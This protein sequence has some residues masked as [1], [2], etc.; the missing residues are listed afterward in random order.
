MSNQCQAT[1][2]QGAR[3]GQACENR[4]DATY[5]LK[6]IRLTLS[7]EA[8][9]KGIRYCDVARGC[10]AILAEGQVSCKTCL[11]KARIRDRKRDD[12]KRSDPNQCL[13]CGTQM[14]AQNRATGK[15]D[16]LLRRCVS[17]YE[18][19]LAIEENRPKRERNYKQ[20]AFQ[21]KHVA[22]NHYVK[23]A[24][25]RNIDFTLSK[26]LFES[27]LLQPCFYCGYAM[28]NQING[29][30]RVDNNKGYVEKNVV[31]CCEPCNALKGT[32]HPQEFMDKMNAIHR[33]TTD[34]T[35]IPT[36]MI[37]TWSSTYR[38]RGMTTYTAYSKGAQSRS[39]PFALSEEQFKTIVVQSCYLCGIASSLQNSNGIDRFDN[40]LGY[41]LENYRPCCGHC[42]LLKKDMS[43]DLLIKKA[44]DIHKKYEEVTTALQSYD[45]PIRAS[46]IEKRLVNDNP[47][48]AESI[49]RTYKPV[50]EIIIPSS[51]VPSI[52]VLLEPHKKRDTAPP[53]QWKVKQ[54]YEAIS[55]NQENQ[56]KDHCEQN[57]DLSKHADWPMTWATFVLGVK[58]KTLAES[59]TTIRQFVESLRTLRHNQL[60]YKKNASVVDREDR[61][62]WPANTVVR[63]FL[64]GKLDAFKKHTE[65]QTGDNPEDTVWQ[66][67]WNGFVTSL[68]ENR[69]SEKVMKALCSKFLTAQRTK[70]YRRNNV[71]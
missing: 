5:C 36:E 66:I 42:N 20:E 1:I 12:K 4:T 39:L 16:K 57:N 8:K 31:A 15:G 37:E 23:G 47:V 51:T 17:C 62:Q 13:D 2:Q 52:D 40:R 64:D 53:K 45:V 67:R 48:L 63:A 56:Y 59:D 7:D 3:K 14:D 30:D 46:K 50:N 33:Y 38:S 58:G 28:S 32:N 61:E 43:Y 11:H 22:W 35:P 68:E 10:I 26:T 71:E 69:G 54:I 41:V 19:H 55:T 6:H 60:C 65:T 18:K 27:L 29:I 34:H 21:N 9:E 24:K 25:K 49:T 44:G 70:R